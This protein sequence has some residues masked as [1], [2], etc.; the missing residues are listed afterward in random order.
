MFDAAVGKDDRVVALCVEEEEEEEKGV[1]VVVER[2]EA[3]AIALEV[4]DQ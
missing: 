2:L 4:F 1:E 3:D